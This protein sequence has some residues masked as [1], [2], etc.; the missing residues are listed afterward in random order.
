MHWPNIWGMVMGIRWITDRHS[1]FLL[2]SDLGRRLPCLTDQRHFFMS[3]G[4]QACQFPEPPG[5]GGDIRTKIC[6]GSSVVL[7]HGWINMKW[8]HFRRLEENF[9]IF[10]PFFLN[11]FVLW[12]L[13]RSMDR[14]A[15]YSSVSLNYIFTLA[16]SD[17]FVLCHE[18][19]RF[20]K[21][22]KNIY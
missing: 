20:T 21:F 6:H 11:H 14:E 17:K 12:I 22:T 13:N 1:V 9:F 5:L 3:T 8:I 16:F 2:V 4:F 19:V 10:L 7:I 18:S 15:P